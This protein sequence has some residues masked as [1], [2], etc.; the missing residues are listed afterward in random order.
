MI[1]CSYDHLDSVCFRSILLSLDMKSW[2]SNSIICIKVKNFYCTL[3]VVLMITLHG[4]SSFLRHCK[5][6]FT[7]NGF[8]VQLPYVISLVT[9]LC[10]LDQWSFSVDSDTTFSLIEIWAKIFA[11][12][13]CDNIYDG[14]SQLSEYYMQFCIT[15]KYSKLTVP[16]HLCCI[17]SINCS[18]LM[19]FCK[20]SLTTECLQVSSSPNLPMLNI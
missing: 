15:Q 18:L 8:P 11:E 13:V 6:F 16:E 5:S 20:Y 7:S 17:F 12:P 1:G 4:V 10:F 19:L 14:L 2:Q 9:F 3:N